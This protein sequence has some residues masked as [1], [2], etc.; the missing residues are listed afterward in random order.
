[1]VVKRRA[2]LGSHGRCRE[3]PGREELETMAP[4]WL[5]MSE[6]RRSSSNR[7][8]EGLRGRSVKHNDMSVT[9]VHERR[10]IQIQ[11]NQVLTRYDSG[12]G[13]INCLTFL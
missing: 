1:M 6:R 3:F 5:R 11:K 12:V 8:A 13:A 10:V 9:C 7:Q 4:A 2:R